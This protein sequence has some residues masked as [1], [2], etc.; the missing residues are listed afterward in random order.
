MANVKS[1]REVEIKKEEGKENL[2]RGNMEV[3]GA[4]NA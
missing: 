1:W 2:G 3:K 4:A